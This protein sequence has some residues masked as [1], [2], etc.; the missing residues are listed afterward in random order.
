MKL[1]IYGL[2]FSAGILGLTIGIYPQYLFELFLGWLIPAVA[3]FATIYFVMDAAKKDAQLV[4]K[5]L[6]KGFV[7]KM[8]YYGIII[9]ISYKLYAFEP[10]PFI[11]SFTGFFLVLHALEA[12]IIKDIS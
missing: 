10:V 1:I 7:I 4:T 3:G 5:V 12:V 9:L 8:I 2:I 6:T 11:I